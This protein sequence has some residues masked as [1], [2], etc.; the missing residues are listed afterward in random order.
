[1]HLVAL[2]LASLAGSRST[3]VGI[4]LAW[5]FAVTWLALA[6]SKRCAGGC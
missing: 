3:I 6:A 5:Q 2:G 4:L 1:M